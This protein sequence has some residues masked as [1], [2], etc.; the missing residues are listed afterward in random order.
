MPIAD[1]YE[2]EQLV[3]VQLRQSTWGYSNTTWAD[4]GEAIVMA[5]RKL[6][7]SERFVFAGQEAVNVYGL[8]CDLPCEL[9]PSMRATLTPPGEDSEIEVDILGVVPLPTEGMALIE[10]ERLE[11]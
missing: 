11:P 7:A 5:V 3:P 8:S 2:A 9:D 4:H 1:W 6:R 10:A